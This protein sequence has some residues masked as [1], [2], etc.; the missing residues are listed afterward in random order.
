MHDG[1][2][3]RD[4]LEKLEHRVHE[5][6]RP[7]RRRAADRNFKDA[8][9]FPAK[10][11]GSGMHGLPALLTRLDVHDFSAEERIEQRVGGR[12]RGRRAVDDENRAHAQ[13]DRRCRCDAR[14][15][16]L[17]ASGR[18]ERVGA[19]RLRLRPEQGQLAHLVSAKRE[20]DRV[21]AF[22]QQ[23]RTAAKDARQARH[24]RDR[25]RQRREQQR[26]DRAERLPQL[27]RC[28]TTAFVCC[29]AEKQIVTV[30]PAPTLLS[31]HT[32]APLCLTMP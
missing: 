31:I 28:H 16:G 8:P 21:V 20:A 12:P 27:R 2:R 32:C 17:N 26:R 1:I 5:R 14:V 23:P 10:T 19:I 11:L 6:E 15:I 22:D 30:V 7:E 4:L 18:D 25:R 29:S 9:A 24:R 13:H 3:R